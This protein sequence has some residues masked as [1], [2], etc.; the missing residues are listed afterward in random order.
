MRSCGDWV[1]FNDDR[2]IYHRWCTGWRNR[3]SAFGMFQ[4][5]LGMIRWHV[6]QMLEA[7][8]KVRKHND[9]EQIPEVDSGS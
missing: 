3:F 2:W 4:V 5:Q 9:R 7:K 6:S 1:N 8:V